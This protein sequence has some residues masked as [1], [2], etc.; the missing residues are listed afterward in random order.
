MAYNR[1]VAGALAGMGIDPLH[2]ERKERETR[3]RVDPRVAKI[4]ESSGVYYKQDD[5][6][7]GPINEAGMNPLDMP[8]QQP[9]VD[10]NNGNP[11][12]VQAQDKPR[13][14]QQDQGQNQ[15][16][17][18][19]PAQIKLKG[20]VTAQIKTLQDIT[21]KLTQVTAN[22]K[23]VDT[24]IQ[25]LSENNNNDNQVETHKLTLKGPI[26]A[27]MNSVKDLARLVE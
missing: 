24:L 19:K 16:K 17:A 23:L 2:K 20:G 5:I 4:L 15:N 13:G 18:V 12:G 26:Q 25:A 9:A 3:S 27:I 21:D 6:Q 14:Q 22:I 1:T 10:P 11:N 7:G 8:G